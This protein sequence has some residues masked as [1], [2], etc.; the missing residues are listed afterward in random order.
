MSFFGTKKNEETKLIEDISKVLQ[1]V[2]RGRLSSR[3]ILTENNTPME[4]IAWDINNA[5]D[6]MEIILRETR[7][8]ITAVSNGDTYR[9]MF[10]AGLHG[11]FKETANAIQKAVASMKANEHYKTMGVLST[12][13][14]NFNGGM[15]GNFNLITTDI[16]KTEEAFNDV[17]KK[18]TEAS[19]LADSTFTAVEKANNE[20]STL[21]E[22]IVNTTDA[23]SEL[24]NNVSDI[25]TVVNLIKDIADQTNLLALNAAIEA[26]R[27]GEHGRGFA[28][29]ADEVRK[30]AERTQKATS[31]ISITIQNLQQQSS[32]ISENASTMNEIASTTNDTMDE[33][34]NTMNNFK[35]NLADTSHTSKK[36][37]FALSL[38][39]YKIQHIIFKSRAYSSVV[40][41]TVTEDIKAT[42]TTCNFG[43]WYYGEGNKL[44]GKFP[45]FKK[46]EAE[47]KAFHQLINEN[48][49]CAL[50]GGCMAKN[51][52][53]EKIIQNFKTAE[54][55]SNNLFALL[56]QLTEEIGE[57]HIKALQ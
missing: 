41:G 11:E 13:F 47:H 30:L 15:A 49:D 1:D 43:R 53:K 5:L 44:F 50:N 57:E 40:N 8:T 2:A 46:M 7:N 14:N 23:I 34:A 51:T 28:V 9:S 32:A 38:S 29:V 25:S 17:T 27:A 21:S 19:T 56:D 42:D 39:V 37:S 4:K 52:Q 20:I 12:A 10:P 31:E 36:S 6:Q 22:L 54:E 48:L 16:S 26:A 35:V 55:H 33:F 3:I 24:D 45:S 18:T